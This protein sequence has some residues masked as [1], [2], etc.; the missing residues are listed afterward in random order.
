MKM[1]GIRILD[2]ENNVVSVKLSDI[3]EMVPNGDTLNWAILFSDIILIPE[4]TSEEGEPIIAQQKQINK[5]EYALPISWE[6]LQSLSKLIHQEIDLIVVACEDKTK[7]I[8]YENMHSVCDIIIEMEDS[9]YWE[10][11]S[12]DERLIGRLTKKFKEIEFLTTNSEE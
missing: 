2:S 11:F 12:T 5:A 10:V 8:Q 1:K 6:R 4:V 9:S 7:L 3:L